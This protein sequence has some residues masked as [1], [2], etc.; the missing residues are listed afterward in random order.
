MYTLQY[1][2]QGETYYDDKCEMCK[3]W[4]TDLKKTIDDTNE[5]TTVSRSCARY[6]CFFVV[7]TIKKLIVWNP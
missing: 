2:H 1:S 6:Q 4:M 3:N 7:I 5:R